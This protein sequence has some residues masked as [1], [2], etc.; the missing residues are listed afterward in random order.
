MRN[1]TPLEQIYEYGLLVN[2]WHD[3]C[4]NSAAFGTTGNLLEGQGASRE[5]EVIAGEGA[6]RIFCISLLS[7]I[8]GVLQSKYLPTGD[9]TAG[10]LRLKLML[11][12]A[13]DGVVGVGVAPKYTVSYVEVML[14][15]TYL[16]FDASRMVSQSNSGGYVISFDSFA[17]L[18][19]SVETRVNNCNILIPTRYSS[20]KTLFT[21]MRL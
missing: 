1:L 2:L 19:S 11:A 13:A 18:A 15:V 17:N 10:D 3:I 5:G 7:G 16:A 12:N 9:M 14:A 6:S 20:L 4:N 8:V 21:I